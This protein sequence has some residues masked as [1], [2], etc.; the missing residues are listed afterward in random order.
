LIDGDADMSG[1]IDH[2][3]AGTYNAVDETVTFTNVDLQT[4]D[5]FTLAGDSPLGIISVQNGDWNQTAT[6]DC[7]C[8]PSAFN[9]VTIDIGHTVTVDAAS[10]A[11]DF[12]IEAGGKLSCS[13][14]NDGRTHWFSA[15]S[16]KQLD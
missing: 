11:N 12:N 16:K 14:E 3:T 2:V 15:K 1:V 8:I 10:F 5:F 4:G 7:A 9:E 13:T 6:W